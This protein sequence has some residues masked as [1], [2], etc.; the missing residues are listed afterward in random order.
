MKFS[1]AFD[2]LHGERGNLESTYKSLPKLLEEEKFDLIPLKEYPITLEKLSKFH[3]LV[4]AQ[5]T[6][7]ISEDEINEIVKF[8]EGGKGLLL[9]GDAGGDKAHKSNLNA[10]MLKFGVKMNEDKVID[11]K[12]CLGDEDAVKI[13]ELKMDPIFE[14]NIREIIYPKGCSLEIMT[15]ALVNAIAWTNESSVPPKKVILATSKRKFGRVVISGSYSQLRYDNNKT[16]LFNIFNWLLGQETPKIVKPPPIKFEIPDILKSTAK[17]KRVPEEIEKLPTSDEKFKS[18]IKSILEVLEEL[19]GTQKDL[20]AYK[21]LKTRFEFLIKML[22]KRLNIE[23]PSTLKQK[24]SEE[25]TKIAILNKKIKELESQRE[26]S[27]NLKGYLQNQRKSK[28]I[29]DAEY[30]MKIENVNREIQKLEE[31]ID[32]L[33]AKLR[34]VEGL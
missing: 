4:I 30:Q 20:D 7:H 24:L 32:L 28:I 3:V 26:S 13:Q 5:P 2:I 31:E 29:S 11:K 34:I 16:L 10:L 12:N 25:T 17:P 1:I 9:L 15:P 22:S 18:Q 33:K 14:Q 19:K 23:L 27:I 8:V 21:V 6:D